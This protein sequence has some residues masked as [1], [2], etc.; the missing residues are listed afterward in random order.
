MSGVSDDEVDVMVM[1]QLCV[2]AMANRQGWRGRLTT[3]EVQMV[4][5]PSAKQVQVQEE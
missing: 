1:R 5:F 3:G 4:S 2:R